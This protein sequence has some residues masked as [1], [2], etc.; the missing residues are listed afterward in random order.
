MAALDRFE[1][2]ERAVQ[3]PP[4]E[5]HLFARM[6]RSIRGRELTRLRED[7][8]G[9]AA[10]SAAWVAS[11]E[12]REAW[13]VDHDA[14]A[15]DSGR[16]RHAAAL[17]EGARGRLHF[18]HDDVRT[19]GT[20]PADV[21]CAENFS[22]SV[23]QTREELRAYFECAR[24]NLVDDGLFVLDAQ[25]GPSVLREGVVE[26]RSL[27]DA[28]VLWEHKR[29]DPISQRVTFAM[30]FEAKG[31]RIEDAFVYDWRLWGLA[32]L[33]EV[34]AEAGFT[35]SEVWWA[36][37]EGKRAGGYRRREEA[38][39]SELWVAYVVGVR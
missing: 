38:P 15:L 5:V 36:E 13:A 1:L 4:H 33:R 28:D 35:S 27:G 31:A 26:R 32:E 30:H 24:A 25:G 6:F 9:T 23:F 11:G 21:V 7:F 2:Y 19:L 37:E 12:D 39:A 18:V 8:A 16:D 17:D 20:P 34:L 22:Y 3:N 29:Y 14:A 10:V